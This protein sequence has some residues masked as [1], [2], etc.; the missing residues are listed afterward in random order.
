VV[1]C[2]TAS[3]A[4]SILQQGET[5]VAIPR[6]LPST[7]VAYRTAASLSPSAVPSEHGDESFYLAI[8]RADL[9]RRYFLSAYLK[10]VYPGGIGGGAAMSLGVKVVTFRVQSGKL[11]VFDA[12]DGK[13]SSDTFDPTLI[14]EAYPII[15]DYSP[16]QH[17]P[18]GEQYVLVDPAAGLN[19]F[20]VVSDFFAGPKPVTPLHF[21]VDLS[22]LEHFRHI[23]D[24]AT[25]EQVFT[26]AVDDPANPDPNNAR[27]PGNYY[28][29]SGTLGIALRSYREGEG[30]AP[31]SADSMN[32][33]YYFRNDPLLVKNT[34]KYSQTVSKW[35][36]HPGMQPIVWLYSNQ[37]TDLQKQYPQYDII[38]AVERGIERWNDVFGYRVLR[39]KM[40]AADDSFA[41]DDKNYVIYDAD[42][43]YQFAFANL[44]ANPNTGELRGAT[45]YFN[46]IWAKLAD[47]YFYDDPGA[48]PSSP[49]PAPLPAAAHPQL[50]S[51]AWGDMLAKPECVL[52]ATDAFAPDA[53]LESAGA[54][55]APGK[56]TKKQK[57]ESYITHVV[58][59]EVGHTLGLR[60][61]F[62][63]SLVPLPAQNSVME[64][65]GPEDTVQGGTDY[66]RPYDVDA[67]KLLYGVSS[68]APVQPFCTDEDAAFDPDCAPFD[69]TEDPLNLVYLPQYRFQAIRFLFGAFSGP[70][71]ATVD[72]WLRAGSPAQQK[73]AFD[74]LF[75]PIL[76]SHSFGLKG[77]VNQLAYHVLRQIYVVPP[78]QRGV[79]VNDPPG[80]GG[81]QA[82][83]LVELKGNLLNSDKQRDFDTRREVVD[84]L[85]QLQNQDAYLILS[86]AHKQIAAVRATLPDGQE[87]ALTDELLAHIDAATH[88]YFTP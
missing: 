26:G 46:S 70:T 10:Q 24:G 56:L 44:R 11:Y 61:N 37:F 28:K 59:H 76:V 49:A 71:G 15:E 13:A 84:I 82:A 2:S 40:A 52:W 57:V 63:G 9:S 62:K 7:V 73:Q 29:I 79:F 51:L 34:G 3:T 18:G 32:R 33:E 58:L 55:V 83:M 35:N 39:A 41:D 66:P 87:A 68:D 47:Y 45:V 14:V 72:N 86:D 69:R 60:H 85:K 25:F 53:Q 54:P 12:G 21:Q 19:R 42:P 5:F 16:F 77:R 81:V 36:I 48:G 38:G 8:K 78:A 50:R 6:S 17:L 20:G 74:G 67:L 23:A 75:A 30:F 64:Y 31:F 88:P 27:G 80:Q 22:F 1:G 43:T 65:L 4:P